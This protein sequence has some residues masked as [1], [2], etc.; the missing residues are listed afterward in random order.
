MLKI[1][2]K[3][4]EYDDIKRGKSVLIMVETKREPA[5]YACIRSYTAESSSDSESR[6]ENAIFNG[7]VD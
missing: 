4:K 1:R 7:E 2:I 3:Q 5:I 6:Y